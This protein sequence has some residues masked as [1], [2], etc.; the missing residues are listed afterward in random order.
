VL[1]GP[2]GAG[3]TTA[4]R[5]LLGI[6]APDSGTAT[7]FGASPRR[8]RARRR[9]GAMLQTGGVPPT[10]TAREHVKATLI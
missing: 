5:V 8:Y 3:K 10:L 4:L 7:L 2:N 6:D 9:V 1:L